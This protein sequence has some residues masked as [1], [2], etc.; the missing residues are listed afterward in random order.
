[1]TM[2]GCTSTDSLTLVNCPP[3]VSNVLTIHGQ[4]FNYNPVPLLGS[5]SCTGAVVSEGQI[6]C[7]LAPISPGTGPLSV[8]AVASVAAGSVSFSAPPTFSQFQSTTCSANSSSSAISLCSISGGQFTITGSNFF[9]FVTLSFQSGTPLA[10]P[11]TSCSISDSMTA[12]CNFS[13]I[14][15][16]SSTNTFQVSVATVGGTTA[17]SSSI[18]ISYPGAVSFGTLSMAGCSNFPAADLIDCPIAG[19]QLT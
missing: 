3:S 14:D 1:L 4:G 12:I 17:F 13:P 16:T 6:T 7:N 18:T 10:G 19:G 11:V 9:N 2:M 15:A 8:S 5:N